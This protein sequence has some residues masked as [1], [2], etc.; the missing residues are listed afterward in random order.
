VR[1]N[2]ATVD[3]IGMSEVIVEEV[4]EFEERF[5]DHKGLEAQLQELVR[6]KTPERS[7]ARGFWAKRRRKA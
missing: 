4:E 2:G 1:R 7:S 5:R 3:G 6:S